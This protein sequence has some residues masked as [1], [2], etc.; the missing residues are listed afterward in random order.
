MKKV[1]A[2]IGWGIVIYAVMLLSW[3][4]F[5][6]YGLT[7]GLLPRLGRLAILVIVATIAGRA[8]R[9]DSWHDILPYSCVWA[10]VAIAFD[11]AFSI[12]FS[13]WQVYLD[14]N[15]WIGYVL[16]LLLP[17]IAPYTRARVRELGP[18]HSIT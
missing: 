2:L 10:L 17:L 9:F 15:I 6:A 11:G 13:G 5:A 4:L 18:E 8:L 12:P 14:W 7:D 3:S 16:V 1:G